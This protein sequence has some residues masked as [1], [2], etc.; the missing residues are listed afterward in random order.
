MG[1]VTLA[2][3]TLA[4]KGDGSNSLVTDTTIGMPK[5]D[6]DDDNAEC[7]FENDDLVEEDVDC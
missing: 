6:E 3:K 2:G 7:I 4:G 5:C 1:L